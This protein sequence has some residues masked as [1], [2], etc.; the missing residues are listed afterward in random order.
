MDS[1][2]YSS[3]LPRKLRI[4]DFFFKKAELFMFSFINKNKGYRDGLRISEVL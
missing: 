2:I 3:E 1:S 4:N